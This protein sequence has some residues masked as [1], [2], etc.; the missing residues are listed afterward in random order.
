MRTLYT[1][2]SAIES[3]FSEN[4]TVTR[5]EC[6]DFAL[7]IVGGRV[8]PVQIQGAFSYTFTAG[9]NES[10]LFQFRTCDS[11]LDM[12]I[13]NLARSVH[14]GFVARCKY[15]GTIGQS[16]P[17]HIYEMDK[18]PGT[19]YIMAR[20]VSVVQPPDAVLR[21]RKT[22]A[23]F[24]RFFAQ[25]WNHGQRLGPK[26]AQTVFEEFRDRFDVLP[27]LLPSRFAPNIA[28][29]C[30]ELPLLF[31]DK[32]PFV[33]SHQD[34]C[35]MNIL[36]HPDTGSITEIVDWVE[37]R[38]LPFGF[39]LWGFE[40][41]LGYMDSEG[42]HYYNNRHELERIFWETLLI[43]AKDMSSN[44]LHLI[45]VARMAGLFCRYGLVMDGKVWKGVVDK[46][47]T[48]SLA[49]LDAFCIS[50]DWILTR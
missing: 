3:F 27:R 11:K 19:T 34:L 15:H 4:T 23:D 26:E 35:E 10:K 50:D 47:D 21:Q 7:S 28:R 9:T 44:D 14:P 6:D 38:L 42:W 40:N 31:S 5:S 25:S 16:R 41:I 39:S 48:S 29:V 33:L 18:L 36:V 20:H 24:A 8:N 17:L 43:E 13:I 32:R 49:Y 45:R 1:L 2:D 37:A 46:S 30:K 22:A 12:S